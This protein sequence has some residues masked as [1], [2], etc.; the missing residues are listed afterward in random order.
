[1]SNEIEQFTQTKGGRCIGCNELTLRYSTTHKWFICVYCKSED[2]VTNAV[3][4]EDIL[5]ADWWEAT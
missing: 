1:M 3:E 4:D 5:I 2:V